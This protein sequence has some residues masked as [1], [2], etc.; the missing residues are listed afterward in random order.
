VSKRVLIAPLHWGLGHATR[1]VPIIEQQINE[2]NVVIVSANSGPRH[3]LE[4]RFPE[5]EFIDIPFMEI[6]YPKDGDMARHF[7]WNGPALLHSIWREHRLLQKSIVEKAIDVVISDSRFG[8]WSNRVKSIFITH[9]VQILSPNFQGIINLMNRW[10]MSKYD[11]VWVPDYKESPGLAGILSH[12]EKLPT[13]ARYIG[14]L[15]RFREKIVP[16]KIVW[17]ALVI[18]SGP[19]PQRSLFEAEMARRFIESDEPALILRGKPTELGNKEIGKL[20]IMN[21]LNDDEL[22]ESLSKSELVISRSGYSSIM[23]YNVL[24]I[25]A[26]LHPTLGQTEQEYLADLH[27]C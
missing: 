24:G 21:H 8:L 11:E 15:S 26:E 2:G 16:H 14:P 3:V 13:N 12:P 25:K 18:I 22:I 4:V 9:Q 27:K 10:V 7:F 17:K 6:T 20:K 5:L 1:C 19:E 23:D